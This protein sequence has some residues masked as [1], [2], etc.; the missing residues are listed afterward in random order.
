MKTVTYTIAG[1]RAGKEYPT[2]EENCGVTKCIERHLT[3]AK[4]PNFWV[5]DV[6]K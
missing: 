6:P 4:C 2:C 1:K 3:K 5:R